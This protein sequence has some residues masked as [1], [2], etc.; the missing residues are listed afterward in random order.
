MSDVE[1]K[2]FALK[3]TL[4]D[5]ENECMDTKK[6]RRAEMNWEIGTDIHY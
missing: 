4:Q 6:G 5:K 1:G 3:T 2:H